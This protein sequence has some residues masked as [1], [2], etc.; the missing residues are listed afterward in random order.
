MESNSTAIE[1]RASAPC[2]RF[3]IAQP[4][5]LIPPHHSKKWQEWEVGDRRGQDRICVTSCKRKAELIRDALEA[6]IGLGQDPN[7]IHNKE[8]PERES[9]TSVHDECARSPLSSESMKKHYEGYIAPLGTEDTPETDAESITVETDGTTIIRD[10]VCVEFA[11]K[12]ERERN[13]AHLMARDMRNQLEKGSPARLIF[14][15]ENA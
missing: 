2:S 4:G 9:E 14:P 6:W 15:W 11:R 12:L 1:G 5:D 7:Q 13:E 8:R 3:F 10:W